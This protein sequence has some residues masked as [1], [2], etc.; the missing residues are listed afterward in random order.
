MTE[1]LENTTTS[2]CLNCH[3][4]LPANAAFCPNCGQKNTD[5]LI[6]LKEFLQNF[7]DNVFNINSRIF[8]TIKWLCIPAKLTKEYFKG[9]HKR[10]YHPIRLYLVMS[11]IFF[12]ILNMVGDID[13]IVNVNLGDEDNLE[14]LVEKEAHKIAFLTELDTLSEQIPLFQDTTAKVA[15]DSLKK[16]LTATMKSDSFDLTIEGKPMKVSS[17][18]VFTL[19]GKELVEK[20]EVKGF[21]AQITAKQVIHFLHD[22]AGFA[23]QVFNNFPLMLL[24]M[25]PFLALFMKLLYVRQGRFYVEHLVLN[26]HH[27]AFMFFFLSFF[28]LLPEDYIEYVIWYGVGAVFIF[29]FLALKWYYEQSFGKTLIKYILFNIFY[30]FSFVITLIITFIISFLLF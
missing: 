8:Q 19:S 9:K 4:Q 7:L 27:H 5:G 21:W 15:L 11:L 26:F 2:E 14:E 12:A 3:Q 6:S 16:A 17:A 23:R 22:Q 18:D 29:L 10:Y 1:N 25:I 13:D 30:L 20:Y 28:F 24:G